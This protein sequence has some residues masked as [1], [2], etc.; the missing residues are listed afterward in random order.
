LHKGLNE[1]QIPYALGIRKN[2][3]TVIE[4][5][6]D[7]F[8]NV[9][10]NLVDAVNNLQGGNGATIPAITGRIGCCKFETDF[11]NIPKM[12]WLN[13][14]NS[15]NSPTQ[16]PSNYHSIWSAKYL[17]NNY[18]IQ[19][20]FIGNNFTN[21]N[22]WIIHEGVRIPFGFEDFLSLIDNSYFYDIDGNPAQVTKIQWNV[23]HDFAVVDFRVNKIYTKNLK[24]SYVEVGENYD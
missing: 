9:T 5:F 21:S 2:K 12:L 23:S 19:T 7:I 10:S 1:V 17:Y 8:V 18:H 4:D 20:S 16:L 13:D 14:D 15:P 3:N 24:E 6:L 22:Q 11:L